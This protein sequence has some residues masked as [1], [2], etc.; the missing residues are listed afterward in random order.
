MSVAPLQLP[1]GVKSSYIDCTTSCGLVFHIISAGADTARQRPL[2]LLTHGYPELAFSWRNII[3]RLAAEGYYVVAPDQRGYGRTTG[4]DTQPFDQVDLNQ[5]TLTNLVRDLVC[6][7]YGLGYEK[8]HCIIGHD[9]GAV[10][11]AMAPLMRP[12]MFQSCVQ[13]SV[14]WN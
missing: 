13:M 3:P 4:W 14:R 8:V 1:E 6:L 5:F 7:V 9:F 11:S 10:S 2:I 12:D